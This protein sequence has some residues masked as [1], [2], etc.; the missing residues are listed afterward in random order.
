MAPSASHTGTAVE[1]YHM[2]APQFVGEADPQSTQSYPGDPRYFLPEYMRLCCRSSFAA[3]SVVVLASGSCHILFSCG[4]WSVAPPGLPYF[5]TSMAV[6]IWVR[7]TLCTLAISDLLILVYIFLSRLL[8]ISFALFVV[9]ATTYFQLLPT[10][11][12]SA[13]SG[14]VNPVAR[15]VPLLSFI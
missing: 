12:R 6:P 4:V 11:D 8:I 2:G 13:T 7:I 10:S 5:A 3:L 9:F 1:C 15:P 14:D